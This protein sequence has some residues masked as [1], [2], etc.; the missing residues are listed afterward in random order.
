VGEDDDGRRG[1]GAAEVILQ[2]FEVLVAE[3]AQPAGLEIDHVDQA[4]EVHAVIVEAVPARAFAA[5]RVAVAVK[6]HVV[7][8][9]VSEL[10]ISSLVALRTSGKAL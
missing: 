5:A 10:P 4:N 2:P 6:L 3:I 9:N 8:E 7:V 1:G